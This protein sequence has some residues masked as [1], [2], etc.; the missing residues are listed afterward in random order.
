MDF[1]AAWRFLEKHKIFEGFFNDGLW[2]KAVKVN[3]ETDAIDDDATK[4][5]KVQIWLE[6]GAYEEPCGFAHDT[7]LDCGGDTFEAAI[8]ELARLV[9]KYYTDNGEKLD[10]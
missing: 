3:P 9:R 10:I 5:T 8:I 1:Y 2:V 7:D 6:C 4:N